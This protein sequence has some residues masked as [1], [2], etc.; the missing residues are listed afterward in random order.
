[1][2]VLALSS[3][4]NSARMTLIDG[5]AFPIYLSGCFGGRDNKKCLMLVEDETGGGVFSRCS[6]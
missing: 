6:H 3:Q 5:T 1:M 2:T 4:E